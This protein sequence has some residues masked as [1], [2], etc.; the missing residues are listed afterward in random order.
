MKALFNK[1][2]LSKLVLA[3]ILSLG[4]GFAWIHAHAEDKVN[5]VVDRAQETHRIQHSINDK[6]N[7]LHKIAISPD[8]E[9]PIVLESRRQIEK[10]LQDLRNRLAGR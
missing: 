3:G 10:E 2:L 4:A 5:T 8:R 1:D 9:N 6:V 7:L